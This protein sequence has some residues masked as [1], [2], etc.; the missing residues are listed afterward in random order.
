[1]DQSESIFVALSAGTVKGEGRKRSGSWLSA[2]VKMGKASWK[3]KRKVWGRNEGLKVG[4]V[5]S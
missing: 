3:T 5:R 2:R 4:K 1:M